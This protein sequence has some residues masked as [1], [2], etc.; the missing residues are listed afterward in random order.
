MPR[1]LL[2]KTPNKNYNSKFKIISYLIS[3]I[4]KLPNAS[5]NIALIR[6][7]TCISRHAHETIPS[8]DLSV[9]LRYDLGK[10]LGTSL[11]QLRT[12]LKMWLGGY[13]GTS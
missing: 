8:Y 9:F 11:D 10:Q 4:V 12:R 2:F 6:N 13:T 7:Y 5:H 3:L 1:Y